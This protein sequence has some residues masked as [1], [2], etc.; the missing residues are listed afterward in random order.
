MALSR[1]AQWPET[2]TS[3]LIP[4]G[5]EALA[6]RSYKQ[7]GQ[8]AGALGGRRDKVDWYRDGVVDGSSGQIVRVSGGVWRLIGAS[9]RVRVTPTTSTILINI[10]ADGD[11]IFNTG[12]SIAVGDTEAI[13]SVL[14]TNRIYP[15]GTLFS[16]SHNT[17]AGA[18]DITVELHY[19][20]SPV[21]Q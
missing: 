12:L 8:T 20:L 5:V 2:R 4:P 10:H 18:E 6:G 21:S 7:S 15:V 11:S 19:R 17:D 16:I 3:I 13:G 14:K 9:A 1:G